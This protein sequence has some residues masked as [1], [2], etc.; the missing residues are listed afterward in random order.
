MKL[1]SGQLTFEEAEGWAKLP[2]GWD[3]G[4]VPGIAVDS[5]DR[6]YAFCRAENPVVIFH[7]DGRYLGSWGE[8][9]LREA[10]HDLHR[11]R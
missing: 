7:R 10:A 4:E 6:V 3:L 9:G 8:R 11:P 2:E 5:K 1:G